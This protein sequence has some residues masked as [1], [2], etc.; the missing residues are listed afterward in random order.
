MFWALRTRMNEQME[1]LSREPESR[2]EGQMPILELKSIMS[3]MKNPRWVKDGP[4]VSLLVLG[5]LSGLLTRGPCSQAGASLPCLF[6]LAAPTPSSSS[7]SSKPRVPPAL[8][9][10]SLGSRMAG[11]DM[12]F[13]RGCG[14]IG[15]MGIRF[16]AAKALCISA[17]LSSG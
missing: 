12:Q 5:Q 1:N 11:L 9:L 13:Q 15:A 17:V 6:S 7:S 2:K 3:G 16:F 8:A 14:C 10:P 4:T